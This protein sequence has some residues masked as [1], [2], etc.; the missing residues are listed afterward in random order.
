MAHDIAKNLLQF[1]SRHSIQFRF[2]FLL[3]ALLTAFNWSSKCGLQAIKQ[4]IIL[5]D[6]SY[7]CV[8]PDYNGIIIISVI[9]SDI[10]L[11]ILCG[12]EMRIE[13]FHWTDL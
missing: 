12:T 9:S 1:A 11:Q 6:A 10:R 3:T 8:V 13:Y 4:S 5:D 2:A 7:A